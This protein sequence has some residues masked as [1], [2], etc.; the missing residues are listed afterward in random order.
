MTDP[1]STEGRVFVAQLTRDLASRQ[2]LGAGMLAPG[3]KTWSTAIPA[4][5][6]SLNGGPV[7]A[8][9]G[10]RAAI[11]RLQDAQGERC[12][13]VN[14]YFKRSRSALFELLTWEVDKHPLTKE[15]REG[16]LVRAYFARVQR[17]GHCTAGSSRLAFI[18]WHA[19]ARMAERSTTDIF[20]AGAV[21]AGCG[22]AGM[23]MRESEKHL[24]TSI[25]YATS[26]MTAVGVLRSVPDRHAFFDV[27]TALPADADKPYQLKQRKQAEQIS[28]VVYRY[29]TEGDADPSGRAGDIPV[30]PFD[31]HDYISVLLKRK[32]QEHGQEQAIQAPRGQ[33][34]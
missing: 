3:T 11:R 5:M 30:I 26:E 24:G 10:F 12:C 15:G 27:L 16:V 4:F 8:A 31:D 28:T 17:N 9:D 7:R 2:L 6:R 25:S 21:V 20:E 19:L 34:P 23:I 32:E 14:G 22:F 13:F 18:S 29:A 33:Q 1:V